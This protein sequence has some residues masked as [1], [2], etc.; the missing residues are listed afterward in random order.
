MCTLSMHFQST[1]LKL[2]HILMLAAFECKIND[3]SSKMKL[4]V[5]THLILQV[6]P[7]CH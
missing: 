1:A 3:N 5:M 7:W 6:F 4:F 2:A